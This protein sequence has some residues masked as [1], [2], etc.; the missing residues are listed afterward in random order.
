[1][2]PSTRWSRHERLF[3]AQFVEG[4]CGKGLGGLCRPPWIFFLDFLAQCAEMNSASPLNPSPMPPATRGRGWCIEGKN[5]RIDFSFRAMARCKMILHFINRTLALTIFSVATTAV[6]AVLPADADSV[7]KNV[8]PAGTEISRITPHQP[9]TPSDADTPVSNAVFAIPLSKLSM[10]RDRP[11]FSPSRRPPPLPA[12]PAVVKLPE[13]ARPAEPEHPPLVLVGTVAGEDSG[14]AVFVENATENIVRLRV[15]ESHQGWILRSI[16]GREVTLLK[17]RK[18]DV[19]AL[20]PPGGS[21]EPAS[22]QAS[23]NPP[24][25]LPKR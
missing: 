16:Q 19:L 4:T 3:S 2:Q 12:P 15:N 17:G 9:K 20:A 8:N 21:S 25:R 14:I 13:P 18:S 24:R 23:L 6:I 22:T 10:T 5:A 11:I 1:M 7:D